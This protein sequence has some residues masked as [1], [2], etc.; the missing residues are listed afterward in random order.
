M[1]PLHKAEWG[2]SNTQLKTVIRSIRLVREAVGDEVDIMIEG[3]GRFDMSTA[4]KIARYMEKFQQ[5]FLKSRSCLR[6]LMYWLNCGA[7]S[8]IRIAA[9]E[10]MY[11]KFDFREALEKRAVDIIQPD[12]RVTVGIGETKK[13]AAMAEACLIPVAP[14]NIHGSI[15]TAMTLHIAA[16]IPNFSVLEHN[17]EHHD[18]GRLFS[19]Q[20]SAE[21]CYITIPDDPGLGIDFDEQLAK[22]FPYKQISMIQD[23]FE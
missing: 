6:I 19:R 14:H 1:G 16:S 12:L 15:G 10:R 18:W 7:K 3:H 11:S 23:M 21:N 8:P 5:P 13:I 4:Y 22:D 2:I 20:F 9:G 17:V